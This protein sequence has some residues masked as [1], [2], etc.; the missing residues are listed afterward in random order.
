MIYIF[1]YTHVFP[2]LPS[3]AQDTHDSSGE[4]PSNVHPTENDTNKEAEDEQ[5]TGNGPIQPSITECTAHRRTACKMKGQCKSMFSHPIIF[6]SLGSS[7][8][9]SPSPYLSPIPTPSHSLPPLLLLLLPHF[10]IPLHLLPCLPLLLLL[11]LRLH[12]SSHV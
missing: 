10:L 5:D 2:V 3:Q 12:C 11:S 6:A 8:S 4:T 7:F 9:P 1:D